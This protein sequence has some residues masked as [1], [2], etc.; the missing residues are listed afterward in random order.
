VDLLRPKA[1]LNYCA[2]SFTYFLLP[3]LASA[4]SGGPLPTGAVEF[5]G[6]SRPTGGWRLTSL[7]DREGIEPKMFCP[8]GVDA[9][10][11][12]NTGAGWFR[13]PLY[14]DVFGETEVRFDDYFELTI[15][16]SY[17]PHAPL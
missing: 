11:D 15:M 14:G 2:Q 10:T 12:P 9:A 3:E 13:V 1:R 17:L 16:S 8:V 6:G 7:D 5:E 4:P